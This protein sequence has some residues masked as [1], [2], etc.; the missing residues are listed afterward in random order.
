MRNIQGEPIVYYRLS[1]Y[2]KM[3]SYDSLKGI[4]EP[5]TLLQLMDSLVN[6][7]H[8]ISVVGYCIFHLNYEREIVLNRE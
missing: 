2:K 4:G 6:V 1:K 7:I 3:G 8:S 5:V